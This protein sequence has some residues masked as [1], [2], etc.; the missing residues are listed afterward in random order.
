MSQPH[1]MVEMCFSQVRTK[2][3][4]DLA[5]IALIILSLNLLSSYVTPRCPLLCMFMVCCLSVSFS[6][7]SYLS[8]VKESSIIYI[9]TYW[10]IQRKWVGQYSNEVKVEFKQ[11]NYSTRVHRDSTV[12]IYNFDK[13][14]QSVL[15]KVYLAAVYWCLVKLAKNSFQNCQNHFSEVLLSLNWTLEPSLAVSHIINW[16][17]GAAYLYVWCHAT[18][19]FPSPFFTPNAPSTSFSGK[20]FFV[21]LSQRTNQAGACAL[22]SAFPEFPCTPIKVWPW[23][24]N[25]YPN[26]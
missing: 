17:P 1:L 13:C 16:F 24:C 20:E 18:F 2:N 23:T 14:L 9:Y 21:G 19:L 11:I 25:I 7:V 5:L 12:P 3:L 8:L 6:P 4:K 22:A 26:H 15:W 10:L